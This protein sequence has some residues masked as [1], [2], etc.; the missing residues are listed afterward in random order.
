MDDSFDDM[1]EQVPDAITELTEQQQE[2]KRYHRYSKEEKV[3]LYD[4]MLEQ[5]YR[6]D[7]PWDDIAAHFGV[8]R[9]T[10][11]D[12]R[13]SDEWRMSEA[14]WRRIM[15]EEARSDATM[16]GSDALG[17]LQDLMHNSKSD[18]VKYSA[19]AKVID[20]TGIGDEIQEAA[21]DQATE[22]NKFLAQNA[23]SKE[24]R[25]KMQEQAGITGGDDLLMLEVKPGGML[26]DKITALNEELIAKRRQEQDILDAEFREVV[27]AK[28][29]E[30]SED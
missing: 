21:V 5:K 2:A 8:A 17:V 3:Q 27:K 28:Q 24:I 15:R 1:P 22:L 11:A 16:M 19:A 30:A 25:L 26:P 6:E 18:F 10:I 12:W 20:I 4:K 23:R 13:R 7:R 9:S 29:E 14:R